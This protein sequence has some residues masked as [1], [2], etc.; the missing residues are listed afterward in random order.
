MRKSVAVLVSA[1]VVVALLFGVA[2]TANAQ[3]THYEVTSYE[4]D[5]TTDWGSEWTEGNVWHIRNI[6]HTNVNISDSPELDGINTTVADAEFNLKN[7]NA[8]IRGTMS[9]KPRTIDGTWEGTWTFI[10]NNGIYRGQAV[11]QGTGA[12]KGK[13][14]FM[15]LFD[16]APAE[17]AETVCASVGG[18]PHGFTATVGDVLVT[19]GH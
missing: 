1:V 17:D 18:V 2:M 13:M 6:V 12:L 9:L 15:E 14:L 3:A 10:A 4:Y 16:A 11:A 7:G 5:C 19:G 8:V